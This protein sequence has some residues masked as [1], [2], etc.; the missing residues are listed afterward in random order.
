MSSAGYHCDGRRNCIEERSDCH[1]GNHISFLNTVPMPQ[2]APGS[3]PRKEREG[4]SQAPR[5][6]LFLCCGGTSLEDRPLGTHLILYYIINQSPPMYGP[7]GLLVS[8]E[9]TARRRLLGT[10]S[11]IVPLSPYALLAAIHGKCAY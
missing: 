9:E 8:M 5:P 2:P 7:S 1:P 10:V 3:C 6:P 11:S 4:S